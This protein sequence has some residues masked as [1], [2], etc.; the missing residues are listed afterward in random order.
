MKKGKRRV[1]QPVKCT[2][3]ERTFATA[4]DASR[5]ENEVHKKLIR[6]LGKK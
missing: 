1:K 6:K 4:L 3:C 2:F 5:H